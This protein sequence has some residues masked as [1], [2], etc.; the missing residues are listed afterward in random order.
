MRPG[1]LPFVVRRSGR[2]SKAGKFVHK[3]N[4]ACASLYTWDAK[5]D[6]VKVF[7]HVRP[8]G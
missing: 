5:P 7:A 2:I 6:E 3:H 8:D 1:E 4:A